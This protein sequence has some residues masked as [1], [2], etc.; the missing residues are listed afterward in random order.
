M[1]IAESCKDLEKL[2]LDGNKYISNGWIEDFGTKVNLK[3]LFLGYDTMTGDDLKAMGT[4]CKELETLMFRHNFMTA[5]ENAI[6]YLAQ[7][8]TKLR[9][10]K[11]HGS[12]MGDFGFQSLGKY[13]PQLECL[14]IREWTS[15]ITDAGIS[16]L[17]E[18]CKK[19]KLLQIEGPRFSLTNKSMF[20]IANNCHDVRTLSLGGSQYGEIVPKEAQITD[21]GLL[22]LTKECK[23][24]K[25]MELYGESFHLTYQSLVYIA[26]NC[27]NIEMLRLSN[28]PGFEFN[29]NSKEVQRI[30]ENCKNLKEFWLEMVWRWFGEEE[31]IEEEGLDE[32]DEE[33][34]DEEEDG[35]EEEGGE[36]L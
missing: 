19:L 28:A 13:C 6:D 20:S 29:R 11:I 24:L 8:C 23:K 4:Y 22:A 32:E 12:G 14:I 1:G 34:E 27:K 2:T 3:H 7:G 26:E 21:D 30:K 15:V 31:D 9:R 33:D 25:R 16:K 5:D 17:V 36:D 18:G 35:E 10:L